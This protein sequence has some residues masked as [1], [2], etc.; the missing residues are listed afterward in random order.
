M[1][2]NAENLTTAKPQAAPG[3][4]AVKVAK[5]TLVAGIVLLV[6][7]LGV[8]WL[9]GSAAVLG[10][11]LESLVNIAA[12]IMAVF[13]TWYAARPPDEDH[14]YGH[15]KIEFVAASFEGTLVSIAGLGIGVEA[16]RRWII[17]SH[18]QRIDAGLIALLVIAALLI[19]L[20]IYVYRSGKRCDS[21]TLTAGG[22]HLATDAI[23]TVGV[24][25]AL[26]LVRMTGRQWIDSAAAMVLCVWVVWVGVGLIRKA[27]NGLL[28]RID[29][30]D[31]AAIKAILDDEVRIGRIMSYEKVRLRHQGAYH[32]VDMHLRFSPEMSVRDAHA[33]ASEIEYRIEQKLGKA[34]ATAH[35]EP[36][37]KLE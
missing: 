25:M 15:G 27:V 21:D 34:N 11:A 26:L 28:D 17:G 7:K 20:A 6:V 9:T 35:I 3:S 5:V 33:A 19:A 32:W 36:G 16:A 10:D 24:A 8:Y 12:A 1:N 31:D 18:V 37:E 23:S 29:E 4:K 22:L 30:T 13:S 2:A 14:P